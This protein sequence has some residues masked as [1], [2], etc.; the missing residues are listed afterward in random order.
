MGKLLLK[1]LKRMGIMRL[2]NICIFKWSFINLVQHKGST[3][4]ILFPMV[5]IMAT[6]LRRPSKLKM[7]SFPLKLL[8]TS[9]ILAD[10]NVRWKWQMVSLLAN[11]VGTM[12][13]FPHILRMSQW[14]PMTNPWLVPNA[15]LLIIFN[16]HFKINN[17]PFSTSLTA[18]NSRC[19]WSN[20]HTMCKLLIAVLTNK[21][22]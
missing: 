6:I 16:R 2:P 5:D 17:V 7:F 14:S 1:L 3:S 21:T 12:L 9:H 15:D 18:S 4:T 19:V 11:V 13:S 8:A 20:Q 22:R 10:E